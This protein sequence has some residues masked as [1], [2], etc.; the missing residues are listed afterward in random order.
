VI[1]SRAIVPGR[2]FELSFTA[3]DTRGSSSG[4]LVSAGRRLR[5]F[6]LC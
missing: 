2:Q 5:S 1:L 3:D 4:Y 6:V